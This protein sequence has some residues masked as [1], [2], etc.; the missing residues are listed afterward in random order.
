MGMP[1]FQQYYASLNYE[2]N[3]LSV[4]HNTNA[5]AKL[6]DPHSSMNAVAISF[7]V[8]GTL[9][10][11]GLLVGLAIYCYKKHQRG[12]ALDVIYSNTEEE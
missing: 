3:L 9:I 5:P 1:F 11:V 6:V 2:T 10:L 7:T 8:I 12:K 4:G